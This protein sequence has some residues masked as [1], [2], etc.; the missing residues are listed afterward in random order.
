MLHPDFQ[1]RGIYKEI[2]HKLIEASET[3]NVG[4]LYGFP[5]EKAKQV[6]IHSAGA[7]DLGNISRYVAMNFL[8]IKKKG[9]H[10]LMKTLSDNE[11]LNMSYVN[12]KPMIH[13]KRTKEF[14]KTRFSK[15]PSIDYYVY[16][17][18]FA[19]VIYR[20]DHIK[21]VIPVYTI[22]DI[23]AKDELS[24][25][26]NFKKSLGIGLIS[27]WGIP[28]S[29]LEQLLLKSGFKVHSSPMPFVVK[30]LTNHDIGQIF[31]NW[32]ILQGDVDSF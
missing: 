23:L 21:T 28:N 2:V 3:Q 1:G 5:A 20:I 7:T 11:L 24:V 9:S 32:R 12:F 4:Y 29:Q 27:T 17:S 16:Q 31:T 8:S 30:T 6:F 25:I 19:Y 13:V 14:L 15:H 18:D 26:K 10:Q 22:V